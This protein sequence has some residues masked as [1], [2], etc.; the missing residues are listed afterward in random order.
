MSIFNLGS[1]NIDNF[2]T[3]SHLP[4]PG[5]T[6]AAL[7]HDI[8]LGGKGAN[9]SVAAALAGSQVFHIGA[10]GPDGAWCADRMKAAGVDVSGV[11]RVQVP[12][13]H[14]NICIDPE[15][16]NVIVLFSGANSCQDLQRIEPILARAKKG[17]T[18][19]L[20]NETN[21]TFEAAQLAKEHG[22]R[23]VYS[24]APFSAEAAAKMFPVI[25]MLVLN[26][27]EADQLSCALGQAVEE[28]DVPSVLITRGAKG[29]R[30]LRR[31]GSPL[32]VPAFSVT[33]VDTTGAGD[34]FLGY[35]AAALD[36][37]IEQEQALILASAASA[38]QVTRKGT[39]D[40]MPDRDE[41]EAFLAAQP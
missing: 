30:L 24:A 39:A 6:L 32:Q 31:N 40:A 41:V 35:V 21:L 14:A 10:I 25:D 15:G 17:D 27:V 3:V 16:E 29:A 23:V 26:D 36:Q 1:I 19:V 4:R 28:L 13:A 7:G 34:C 38:I 2:Y 9:Q 33:P 22:L 37:G 8:G 20:Q 5:E 12:T 11:A 18:F